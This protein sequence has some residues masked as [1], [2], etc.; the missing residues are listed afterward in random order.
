M[1]MVLVVTA[2]LFSAKQGFSQQEVDPDHYDQPA[3]TKSASAV[4]KSATHH[5]AN[6]KTN[7]A[8]KHAKRHT[9]HPVA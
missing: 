9:S 7:L 2:V 1:A 5:Y 6:G 8:S 3:A 4:K